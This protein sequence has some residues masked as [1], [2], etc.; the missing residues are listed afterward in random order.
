MNT[1]EYIF[2]EAKAIETLNALATQAHTTAAQKGWWEDR[3]ALTRLALAA[4]PVDPVAR[5]KRLDYAYS[6][7]QLELIALI[8]SELGEAVEAI[9]LGNKPDDKIPA[10]NGAT[11]E[12]ADAIIRILDMCRYH[13]WPIG[14]AIVA[15]MNYNAT[16]SHKHGGKVL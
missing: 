10:F 13:D 11:A 14:E 15:K 4:A 1:K 6:S 8:M 12:L 9:R 3:Y 7:T 16:R 2:E 5:K